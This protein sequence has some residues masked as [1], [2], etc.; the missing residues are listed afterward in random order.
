MSDSKQKQQSLMLQ[1]LWDSEVQQITNQWMAGS[2]PKRDFSALFCT[3]WGLLDLHEQEYQSW[4]IVFEDVLAETEHKILGCVPKVAH[5]AGASYHEVAVGVISN[6]SSI[7][8]WAIN[9]KDH[10]TSEGIASDR[11][12]I[13]DALIDHLENS[14]PDLYSHL[15]RETFTQHSQISHG[16]AHERKLILT[17]ATP[18][19]EPAPAPIGDSAQRAV[20]RRSSCKN[21]RIV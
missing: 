15:L 21:L 2:D 11:Q 13:V 19:H 7:V 1:R 3:A 12:P 5:L 4:D 14:L 17:D 8:E 6:L 16:L 18:T 20:A 10:A 9:I